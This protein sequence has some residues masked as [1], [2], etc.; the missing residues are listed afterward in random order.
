MLFAKI[1]PIATFTQ[2]TG[3]FTAPVAVQA[4]YLTALAR[5]YAAG[6]LQTNFEIAFGNIVK[7]AE[8]KA[9]GVTNVSTSQL[10]LTKEELADW[11]TND[12]ILLTIVATKLGTTVTEFVTVISDRPY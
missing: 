9:I 11:G 7:D 8:G 6:A 5:P 12:D 2:N 10:T 4:E 1:D 3:P